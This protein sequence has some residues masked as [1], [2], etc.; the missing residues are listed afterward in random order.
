MYSR[1]AILRE[2]RWVGITQ[3]DGLRRSTCVECL[4]KCGMAVDE[5]R[6]KEDGVRV[7]R[8]R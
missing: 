7:P 4:G 6:N 5:N 2:R 8:K 3:K 1:S